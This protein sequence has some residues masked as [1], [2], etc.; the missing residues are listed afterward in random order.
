M[1]PLR[2]EVLH[3]GVGVAGAELG[4]GWLVDGVV[5]AAVFGEDDGGES[6]EE[7]GEGAAG[8]D[9]GELVVVADED[10]FGVGGAGVVE[11]AG[12]SAGVDH[13]GFVDDEHACA[14]ESSLFVGRVW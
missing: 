10:D 8:F 12:E 14:R 6:A 1:R 5:L 7:A 9:L 13:G 2:H 11:E 4:E 3:G